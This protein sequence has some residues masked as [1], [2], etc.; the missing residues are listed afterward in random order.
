[1]VEVRRWRERTLQRESCESV[2]SPGEGGE[3]R[4]L[5]SGRTSSPRLILDHPS[6]QYKI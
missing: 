1:M 2:S 3:G 6:L 5:P 4:P